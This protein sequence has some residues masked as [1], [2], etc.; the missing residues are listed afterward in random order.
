MTTI[1]LDKIPDPFSAEERTEI[2]AFW[3]KV[4]LELAAIPDS[5]LEIWW[6]DVITTYE[7]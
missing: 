2:S 6:D 3:D 5:E 7:A 4:R 1:D